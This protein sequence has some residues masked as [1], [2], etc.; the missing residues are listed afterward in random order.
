MPQ[1]K[2]GAFR[3]IALPGWSRQ[4]PARPFLAAN[5]ATSDEPERQ[6]KLPGGGLAARK[7]RRLFYGS[8]E[9]DRLQPG[10]PQVL[11]ESLQPTI[12]PTS[13]ERTGQH[14]TKHIV[15]LRVVREYVNNAD[16]R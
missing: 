10:V 15:C 3:F 4:I 13:Y 6:V 5:F 9:L 7:T 12:N 16:V 1:R 2:T 14:V 8:A 11:S